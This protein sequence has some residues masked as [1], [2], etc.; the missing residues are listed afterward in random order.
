ME[1]LDLREWPGPSEVELLQE[2][3]W[4]PGIPP[5]L[6]Q[7]NLDRASAR[8]VMPGDIITVD[9]KQYVVHETTW[10]HGPGASPTALVTVRPLTLAEV[11]SV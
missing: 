3:V 10:E 2:E 5:Q 6:K 7:V 9:G 11:A 1:R 8:G 4:L